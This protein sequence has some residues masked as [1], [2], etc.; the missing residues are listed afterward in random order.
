MRAKLIPE[1]LIVDAYLPIS[2]LDNLLVKHEDPVIIKEKGARWESRKRGSY[3]VLE[4]S[5]LEK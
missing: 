2:S 5:C 3:E 1:N 4:E